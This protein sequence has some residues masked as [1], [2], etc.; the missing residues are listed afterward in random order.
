MATELCE[1]CPRFA[2]DFSA[3]FP[4]SHASQRGKQRSLCFLRRSRAELLLLRLHPGAKFTQE[5]RRCEEITESDPGPEGLHTRD[6]AR[7]HR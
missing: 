2:F 5:F 3:A 4:Q 1:E 7:M 6:G